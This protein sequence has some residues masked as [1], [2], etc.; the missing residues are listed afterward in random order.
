MR[1]FKFG[2]IFV[3]II[4][5]NPVVIAQKENSDSPAVI[6]A[7]APV[8]PAIAKAARI[9]GDIYVDVEVDRNGKVTSADARS[10]SR[11]LR[12][13]VEDTARRWSFSPAPNGEK[14]RK[15]RLTFTFRIMPEKTPVTETTS[16]FYPPYK[17]EVRT[18]VI[19]VERPSY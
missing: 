1:I 6:S 18:I 15:A 11:L 7:V 17:I 19:I 12:K 3:I 9:E 4:L 14:K 16:I 5:F 2:L 10:A 8:Y 13:I